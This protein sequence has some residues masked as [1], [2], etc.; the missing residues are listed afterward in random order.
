MHGNTRP[1]GRRLSIAVLVKQVPRFEEFELGP[2]GR[3]VRAGLELELNPYCRRAVSKGVELAR[4]TGGTCTVVTLGPPTAEECLREAVAW[5]ADK[6]VLITD[7]AFAGSDTLATARALASALRL[8]GPF[9]LILCGRNSVDA[10]TGQTPPEV[11]ELLDLPLATGVRELVLDGDAI[12]VGCEHDDGWMRARLTLPAVLS[13]AERLCE[14]A[15]SDPGGC[16]A[17]PAERI[18][19]LSAQD[20]GD[21][22]WGEAGSPTRVGRVQRLAVERL[23]R[24]L[25][26]AVEAQVAEAVAMLSERGA[27]IPIPGETGD[28]VP[29]TPSQPHGPV[30]AVVIE[31]Q[32]PRAARELLGAAARLAVVL[33]GWVAA[34]S[35]DSS[36]AHSLGMRG[37]DVVVPVAG[38]EVEE[39]VARAIAGWC[40]EWSPW[41]VLVPSTMWGREVAARAAARIGAGLVG[42]AVDVDVDEGR[43]VSWKPAF[44]G[45]LV[46]SVTCSTAVQM[47]TVRPGVFPLLQPRAHGAC[48]GDP[49]AVEAR[50]RVQVIERTRDDDIEVLAT[51]EVVVTVGSCIPPDG[52]ESLRPL[53]ETLGAEL[54]ATRKVTDKGWLPHSRQVGITGR[55]VAPRLYV[56]LGVA[57]KFNHIVGA[58]GAGLILA[59]NSDA[60]APIF[61]HCDVGIVADWREVV[62]RLVEALSRC[63][64]R[65][66][67]DGNQAMLMAHG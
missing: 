24:R 34:I 10:D 54:A 28:P 38:A 13:C 53:L 12:E 9:D 31:P 63:A 48:V 42:D 5:G 66:E 27:F 8:L 61:A 35:T 46:A 58:R 50:G 21:G 60:E 40:A 11:A 65:Y 49:V 15:K 47:V 36:D 25:D 2:D 52:Y 67:D 16:A 7:R 41:A 14:P 44:G 17:V 3:L 23:R 51:A 62:P 1:V 19:R 56:A 33:G 4:A 64:A 22:P 29:P 57:G 6:G 18:H 55:S 37:A 32:R 39:D 45:G 26:G 20:L 43:L 30:I 59:V